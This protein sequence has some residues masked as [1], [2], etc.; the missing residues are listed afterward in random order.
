MS[1]VVEQS[2]APTRPGGL[3]A[4]AARSW[5]LGRSLAINMLGPWLVYVGLQRLYPSPSLIPLLGSAAVPAI[6]LTVE[7]AR[8]RTVD[9]VAVIALVQ[10]LASLAIS[11][12]AHEPHAAMAGHALQPAALGAVFLLTTLVGRPLIVMLARQAVAGDNPRR[13]AGFDQGVQE[14]WMRRQFVKLS[15]A[16]ALGLV[17]QSAVQLMA[18]QRLSASDYLLFANLFGWGLNGVMVWGSLRWG[19]GV[20]RRYKAMR[21]LS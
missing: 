19:K 17:G 16:W 13:Q 4:I 20:E 9:A 12:F 6:D 7:F 10:L 15:V 3:K 21:G 5:P 2:P 14:P 8:R 1:A 18:L 11:L